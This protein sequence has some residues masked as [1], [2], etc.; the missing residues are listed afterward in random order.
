MAGGQKSDGY[1]DDGNNISS[2]GHPSVQRVAS[3]QI[4]DESNFATS[5][6]EGKS[7]D[8]SSSAFLCDEITCVGWHPSG[9]AIIHTSDPEEA[10]IACSFAG[11]II[12]D[13]AT[14]PLKCANPAVAVVT[15]RKLAR[16]GSAAVYLPLGSG[17]A[18]EVHFAIGSADR[19]WH[20]NRV[21]SREARGLPP[22]QRKAPRQA[23]PENQ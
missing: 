5:S 10:R 11:V 22:Y 15:K 6:L 12:L 21:F 14:V 19:P 9:A 7:T 17:D 8:D 16:H 23:P 20:S 1:G 3:T 13:D 4:Q 18:A 2:D